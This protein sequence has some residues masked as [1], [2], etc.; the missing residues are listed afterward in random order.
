MATLNQKINLLKGLINGE[1][2]RTGPF[3]FHVVVDVTRRCNLRCI[4]CRF[5]SSLA[6]RPSAGDQNVIDMP[7]DLFDSLCG[8]LKEMKTTALFLMGEGEPFLYDHILDA[9]Y[10]AKRAGFRTTIITNGTL[11][12]RDRIQSLMDLGLDGLQVTLWSGC[13]EGYEQQ[14]PGTDPDNFKK[15][16]DGLKLVHTLKSEQKK[17]FPL[18]T[19]HHPINRHNFQNI[20]AIVN[21]ALEAGCNAIS[22]SPFLSANVTLDS[23]LL[24]PG[25]EKSLFIYLR[26][27]EKRIKSLPLAHNIG[28]VL[29][30]YKSGRIP[31]HLSPCY[32]GWIHTRVKVDG[33][34][35]PCGFCDISMGN[36]RERS[37]RKIWN[38]SPYRDFRRQFLTR[39]EL[40]FLNRCNCEFC[41]YT[42]DNLRIHRLFR[43]LSPF[44]FHHR[45]EVN[46]E[47]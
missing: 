12:D 37:F 22:F 2:I 7:F 5:H 17:K 6:Q 43:W 15:V 19:L 31:G 20:D 9:V 23:Y 3:P 41:C 47:V 11:L 13:G 32:I 33:T 28:R 16:V 25:Q 36:L 30:R 1:I 21:L 14:Y 8:E 38:D 44:C 18:V 45:N 24:S 29:L 46:S 39:D 27:L 34:V 35:I 42:Q 10:T 4:G 40:Q 26:R